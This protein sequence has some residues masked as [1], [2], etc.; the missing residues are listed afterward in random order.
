MV[1]V[2]HHELFYAN[3]PKRDMSRIRQKNPPKMGDFFDE[4]DYAKC[5]RI[6]ILT[7]LFTP[8]W[9]K[10]ILTWIWKSDTTVIIYLIVAHGLGIHPRNSPSDRTPRGLLCHPL[11]WSSVAFGIPHPPG[12][13]AYPGPPSCSHCRWHCRFWTGKRK[14]SQHLD[15]PMSRNLWKGNDEFADCLLRIHADLSLP[16]GEAFLGSTFIAAVM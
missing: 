13:R 8:Y 5:P 2:G 11:L 15:R 1:E 3:V 12:K 14:V 6:L 16:L 10:H 7:V 9:V 4:S